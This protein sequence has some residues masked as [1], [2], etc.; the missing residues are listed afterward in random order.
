MRGN[1]SVMHTSGQSQPDCCKLC[2]LLTF[3]INSTPIWRLGNL[4]SREASID[5]A[6]L[7][8]KPMLSRGYESLFWYLTYQGWLQW[9]QIFYA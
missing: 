7:R 6:A 8:I 2:V 5:Y 1:E 3:H 9:L 4:A